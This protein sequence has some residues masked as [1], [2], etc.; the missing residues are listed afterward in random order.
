VYKIM[1]ICTGANHHS[2]YV[3]TDISQHITRTCTYG[4]KQPRSYTACV[5]T[6]YEPDS[7]FYLAF[8]LISVQIYLPRVCVHGVGTAE[9]NKTKDEG[10]MARAQLVKILGSSQ[11]RSNDPGSPNGLSRPHPPQR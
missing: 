2:V 8:R 4:T 3:Y 9:F 7:Q 5:N 6:K 10:S 11:R 1:T